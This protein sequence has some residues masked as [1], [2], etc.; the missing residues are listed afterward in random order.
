[1]Q[2]YGRGEIE[3]ERRRKGGGRDYY[4]PY[5]R[6]TMANKLTNTQKFICY[7]DDEEDRGK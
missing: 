6:D 5:N 1:M 2:I 3:R 7:I 4:V